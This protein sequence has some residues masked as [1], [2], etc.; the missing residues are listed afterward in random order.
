[1]P[2]S[3]GKTRLYAIYTR[4]SR[5]KGGVKDSLE[6]QRH[7]C[8]EFATERDWILDECF[9]DIGE[10]SETLERPAL[11]RL[12]SEI[13]AGRIKRIVVYSIDRLTRKLFDLARLLD[14][15]E[16]HDVELSVVTDPQFGESAAARLTSN[17]V[18]A[19]SEFQL[20]LTR[21]RMAESRSA[22]K[23]RGRR[24]AGRVPYG[25][26]AAPDTK[27]LIVQRRHA[28]RIRKIFEMASVGMRPTEICEVANKRRWRTDRDGRWTARTILKVLSNPTYAGRIRNSDGTLPGQHEAIVSEELFAK[29]R[30]TIESRRS[31][32]PGRRPSQSRWP[33]RRKLKCGRCGRAMIPTISAR[34][35]IRYRYYRCRSTAGGKPPCKSVSLSAY[36]IESFVRTMV[37]GGFE[38]AI[39]TQQRLREAWKDLTEWQQIDR[40]GEVVHEVVFDPDRG[41]VAVKLIDEETDTE[42]RSE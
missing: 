32:K 38:D 18:A 11:Q 33:L 29:V 2:K 16:R 6:L 14:R 21:E 40:L 26:T 12:L 31:R 24:V 1:M 13:E 4:L 39:S 42:M 34:G 25:Y 27:Q 5:P 10:S 23:S 28:N 3:T 17:I 37:F 22:H 15:F 20:E 8:E 19:A 36:Q 9:D 41:T 30:Q 7:I 35:S